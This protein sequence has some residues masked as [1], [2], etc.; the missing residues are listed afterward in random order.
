M[1]SYARVCRKSWC[2]SMRIPF[3]K[4]KYNIVDIEGKLWEDYKEQY[5]ETNDDYY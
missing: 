5:R 3:A 1:P 2:T 4:A